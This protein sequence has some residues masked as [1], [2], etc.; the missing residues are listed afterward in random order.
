MIGML[1]VYNYGV[2]GDG[3]S[4]DT[5]ALQAALNAAFGMGTGTITQTAQRRIVLPPGKFVVKGPGLTGK[6]W[7]GGCLRGSGRFATMIQ[8]ADGGPVI[9][10]DG[11][12]Y[13]RFEDMQLDGAGGTGVLFD[14]DWK[15]IGTALQSNTFI[16]MY[17]SSAG[18]GTRIANDGNMGSEN[19]FLNCFF[20][21]C[22][23]TGLQV[24]GFNALQQT[25]IG[26][27]FQTC[28]KGIQLVNGVANV[29]HGVGFQQSSI[30][31]ISI[32]AASSNTMSVVGCRTE[33]PN[34]ISNY[35]GHTMTISAC[36]QT[37]SGPRG[38]FYAGNGGAVHM[39]GCL[40]DG[41]VSP[42]G[43]SRFS[44]QSCY[45]VNVVNPGDWLVKDATTWWYIPNN[46]FPLNIE[47]ENIVSSF[48]NGSL[49]QAIGKQRLFTTDGR[50]VTT[51]NY[52][53]Q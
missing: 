38:L 40:F 17:F 33:S 32:E 41:Q 39:S 44:M 31:D 3:V 18:I 28:G 9:T 34:F 45:A 20:G 36:H 19:L 7:F 26:G 42:A 47:L 12:Q 48:A 53:V 16:N 35:S 24:V 6:N 29:I 51:Q 15:G 4:D 52:M 5:A 10:T 8:N 49:D 2:R 22:S 30:A 23:I 50:T 13:M 11:C 27:N 14:L 25:I 1:D 37:T 21:N 46:Q 43:W